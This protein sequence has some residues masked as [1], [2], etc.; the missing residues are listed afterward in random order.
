MRFTDYDTKVRVLRGSQRLVTGASFDNVLIKPMVGADLAALA[1][2]GMA[3]AKGPVGAS[4][5]VT[6]LGYFGGSL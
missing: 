4:A 5:H 3:H 2:L 1:P 6:N